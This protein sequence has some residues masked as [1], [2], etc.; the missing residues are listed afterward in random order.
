MLRLALAIFLTLLALPAVA[1]VSERAIVLLLPTDYYSAFGVLAVMFTVVLTVVIP[2][3]VFAWMFAKHTPT[4]PTPKPVPVALSAPI[5]AIAFA[6]FALLITLGLFGPRD[7]LVNLLPLTVF[8]V[9]WI[10]LLIVQATLGNIWA[11]INPWT[12]PV[13]WAFG[14]GHRFRLPDWVGAGPAVIGFLLFAAYYLTDIAPDDPARL[15]KFAGGYWLFTFA[16]CGVFGR[17]WLEK[18]ESFTVIFNLVGTLALL[19]GRKL[20]WP[21]HALVRFAKPS[22]TLALLSVSFLAIGSF[23]GLNE[24]FWWFGKLGL[25]PLEFAGR[26]SVVTENLLGMAAA[27]ILLNLIFSACIWAGYLLAGRP[28][29]FRTLYTRLALTILPI[30][31]GYHLAHYLTSVMIGLQYWLAALDDPLRSGLHILGLEDFH[32]TTGFLNQ[33]NTV[34]AIWLTQAGAIVVGH[35]MAVILAHAISLDFFNSHKTALKSQ[36]FIAIFMVAYTFF[37]LWLLA[38]PTAL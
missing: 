14:N 29:D 13:G 9:W 17:I 5:H 26:S 12:G 11:V 15:A 6:S 38:S 27:V 8:T 7:P 24:T 23:D 28:G 22:M 16:M 18:C 4:Q 21:G 1:H 37:G 30:G 3:K 19:Q 10:C 20:Q 32:V 35:I 31:V 34:T 33:Y 25:N 36:V 2:P